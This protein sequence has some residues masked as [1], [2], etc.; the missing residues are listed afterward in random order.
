MPLHCDQFSKSAP[1]P[2]NSVIFRSE[3]SNK[4][5]ALIAAVNSPS[6]TRKNRRRQSKKPAQTPS[7]VDFVEAIDV[8]E[9]MDPAEAPEDAFES[10][11]PTNFPDGGDDDDLMIDTDDV[12]LS[13]APAFPPLPASA[14]HT[15]LKSETRR[16]AIP[17]HRMTPLKKDWI[18][19]F[20]P[21]TEILGLQ[22]RMNVQRK[23][24]EIRVFIN[25]LS[26]SLFISMKS[27]SDIQTYERNFISS[28]RRRLCESIRAWVRREC[29]ICIAAAIE[30]KLIT[31]NTRMPS[32]C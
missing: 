1:S 11:L 22:V 28:K 29:M 17:P 19:I 8:D 5:V 7:A 27:S 18:T 23:C 21:L 10:Q 15:T 16:V 14:L 3:S 24:V 25:Q 30:P 6:A 31:V 20:G 9:E 4:M 12:P 13:S 26:T 32:L 2:C